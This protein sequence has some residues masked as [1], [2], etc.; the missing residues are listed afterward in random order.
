MYLGLFVLNVVKCQCYEYLK[1]KK[2][3]LTMAFGKSNS[4]RISH[5][6]TSAIEPA[7]IA[8]ETVLMV[9]RLRINKLKYPIY[10]P[11]LCVSH[12]KIFF[13]TNTMF[14]KFVAHF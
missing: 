11:F 5:C 9:T 4:I 7:F 1:Q 3:Q 8:V 6:S 10:S 12:H 14:A 13:R 2:G